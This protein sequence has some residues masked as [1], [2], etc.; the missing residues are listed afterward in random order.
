MFI[1]L[2]LR[3][4]AKSP[5]NDH[6]LNPVGVALDVYRHRKGRYMAG[7][8]LHMDVEGRYRTTVAL[9]ADTCPINVIKKL[10][11][12]GSLLGIVAPL[13]PRAP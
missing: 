2:A 6:F 10:H 1:L 4:Q 12:N 5:S 7:H 3:L 9:R 11:F 13:G 8:H